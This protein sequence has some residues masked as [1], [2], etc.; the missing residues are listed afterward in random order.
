[1]MSPIVF[2]MVFWGCMVMKCIVSKYYRQSFFFA[3]DNPPIKN[4]A[5]HQTIIANACGLSCPG[6]GTFIPYNPVIIASI[7][8]DAVNI[9]N[10]DMTEFV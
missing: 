5:I 8:I 10:N 3:R 2:F 7:P 4:T 9:V 6:N 1:M